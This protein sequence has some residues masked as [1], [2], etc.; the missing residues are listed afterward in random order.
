MRM[1]RAI[2]LFVIVAAVI[3]A[4][5]PSAA[6][7]PYDVVLAAFGLVVPTIQVTEIRS[8]ATRSDVQPAVL[9]SLRAFRA[10]P[11]SS[12]FA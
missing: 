10:P 9:F 4:L 11:A 2:L 8:V 12:L 6:G 1:R 3:A 5:T 7:H